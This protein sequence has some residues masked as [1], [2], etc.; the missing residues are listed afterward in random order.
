MIE[1][2]TG[3][4][5]G[6]LGF[7]AHG[8]VTAA[9]YENVLVPDVEAAFALN[10]K[11]RLIY[12]VGE[13]FTGF[14]AGAL[15]DDTKL[16]LRHVSGWDRIALVTDVEWLRKAS[17]AFRFAVPAEFKL[18]GNGAYDEALRWITR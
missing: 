1:Q 8:Q 6:T 5:A 14:D 7:R 3:L 18:F 4:P 16:G 2:I 12:H 9:D 15:W 11:L 10:D 13:D 17:H